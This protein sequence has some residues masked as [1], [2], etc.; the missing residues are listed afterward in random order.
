M[1]LL[2]IYI[3]LHK[4]KKLRMFPKCSNYIVFGWSSVIYICIY[5][6]TC[7]YLSSK[8]HGDINT[9]TSSAIIH[10][11]WQVLQT[12]SRVRVKLMIINSYWT[13]NTGVSMFGSTHENIAYV[14]VTTIQT[15]SSI[16]CS[17]NLDGL[18]DGRQVTIHL[19][20]CEIMLLGFF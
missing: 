3:L 8:Y 7:I 11:S 16:S 20:L 19:L 18:C 14:F 1:S 4:K 5:I 15:V 12:V 2:W 10:R 17:S 9:L 13:A 6:Y